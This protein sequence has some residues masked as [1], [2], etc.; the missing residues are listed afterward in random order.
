MLAATRSGPTARRN[1][2]IGSGGG[3]AQFWWSE[4]GRAGEL[5]VSAALDEQRNEVADGCSVV[6][7]IGGVDHVGDCLSSSLRVPREKAVDDLIDQHVLFFAR[8]HNAKSS[9]R[10]EVVATTSSSVCPTFMRC[11]RVVR[12]EWV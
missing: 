4:V 1:G 8:D 9:G 10:H 5:F 2:S 11:L 6:S 3:A 12:L 7:V